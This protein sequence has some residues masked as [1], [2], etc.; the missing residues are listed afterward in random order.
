MAIVGYYDGSIVPAPTIAATVFLPRLQAQA[1]TRFVIDT[2]ADATILHTRGLRELGILPS[3]LSPNQFTAQG[4]GGLM[5][6]CWEPARVSLF[7]RDSD[8][9]RTFALNI[10][11]AAPESPQQ[12]E[13]AR[14]FPSL[15][16]RDILNRCRCVL[17]PAEGAVLLE[18]RGADETIVIPPPRAP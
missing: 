1:T 4:I 2:G 10:A 18:P 8:R 7:D 3:A 17:D 16:G 5:R 15:L 9:W 11:I 6:Y 14:A 13:T 12:A